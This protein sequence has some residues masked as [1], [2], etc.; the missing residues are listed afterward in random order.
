[1]LGSIAAG[2]GSGKLVTV[3]QPRLLLQA[4]M[5]AAAAGMLWLLAVSSPSMTPMVALLPML[6]VGLG[7]GVVTTQ[8]SNV[9]ISPLPEELQGTGS[10]FAE[11]AK[12]LGVGMGTAVI[13][14]I[15]FSV[16]L[17]GMVDKV[18]LEA[19]E[20]ITAQERTELILQIEDENVPAE[21]DRI[22]AERVPRLEELTREAYVEAFQVTLG[23][24]I[25]MVLLA[26]LIAAFI[27]RID[28]AGMTRVGGH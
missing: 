20:Q 18:A 15:M 10:G 2:L 13:G 11:M 17:G 5:A 6:L 28:A 9:L 21:V 16:A 26:M 1:M 4:S 12:E 14:S 27:P 8:V 23:V 22:V 3:V 7:F 19:G 24:L 25:A